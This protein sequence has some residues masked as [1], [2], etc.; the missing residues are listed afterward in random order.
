MTAHKTIASS[1]LKIY[2]NNKCLREVNRS[3]VDGFNVIL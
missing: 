2:N 1:E 3:T